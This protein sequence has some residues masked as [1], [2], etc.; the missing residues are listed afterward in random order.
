VLVRR[1][2]RLPLSSSESGAGT[3]GAASMALALLAC[4]VSKRRKGRGFR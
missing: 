2:R 3:E 1:H 4:R